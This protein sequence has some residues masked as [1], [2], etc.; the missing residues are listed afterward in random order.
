MRYAEFGIQ[1]RGDEWKVGMVSKSMY[2]F[3]HVACFIACFW[4]ACAV[5]EESSDDARNRQQ[6]APPLGIKQAC[7]ES[8][9]LPIRTKCRTDGEHRVPSMALFEI[10]ASRLLFHDLRLCLPEYLW[11]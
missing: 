6:T 2:A 9:T 4:P 3:A 10:A 11:L 1:G 5:M 8:L 7:G